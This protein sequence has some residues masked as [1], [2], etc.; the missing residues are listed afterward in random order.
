MI[1]SLAEEEKGEKNYSRPSE[2]DN[3]YVTIRYV[4][5]IRLSHLIINLGRYD[6]VRRKID[7][8]KI[9]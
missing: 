2:G 7:E 6:T 1:A 3:N 4:V 5:V 8:D 9:A